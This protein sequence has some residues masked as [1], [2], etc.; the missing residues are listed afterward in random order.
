MSQNETS[1]LH[2]N[3]PKADD[4]F[5][6]D[7]E[8]EFNFDSPP[9][10]DII[11]LDEE[12]A[13]PGEPVWHMDC[14]C[15]QCGGKADADFTLVPQN[16]FVIT[17]VSCNKEIH[18]IRES[19]AC[20]VKRK[21]YEI[22]CANCGKLLG[23]HAHCDS[24]GELFP[25]YFVTV[26]PDEARHKARSE[27]F[28]KTWSAIKDL[29][30]SF[31]PVFEGHSDTTHGNYAPRRAITAAAAS[32]ATRVLAV[33]AILFTI[34]VALV[35][36]GVFAYNSYKAGQAY[37]ENYFKAL[38]CIKTGIDTNLKSCASLK[39][40]WESV[41][42]RNFSPG[43]INID[44]KKSGKVRSEVD[45]YLLKMSEPPKKFLPSHDSLLKLHKVYLDS[46]DLV[47]TKPNSPQALG[48]SIEN[49][50][51]NMNQ[52]SQELKSSLPDSLKQELATAKLKYRGLKDF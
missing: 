1:K 11:Q 12:I 21:P 26:D 46:E 52:A 45:K 38:Y 6:F 41:S 17:C 35:V 24:C 8:S 2:L 48:N 36:A 42:G 47:Q 33:R 34:A 23:K 18:V 31:E 39:A 20:R 29:N 14:I 28:S 43:I 50:T 10:D 27:F 30:I 5:A 37:A 22:N 16:G 19:G 32:S 3:Q 7:E 25:D 15:L 4:P 49:L 9:P 40:E 44:E 13:D 51:K